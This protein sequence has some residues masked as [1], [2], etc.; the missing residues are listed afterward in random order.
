MRLYAI[1]W[2]PFLARRKKMP[3][4]GDGSGQ[5]A[6]EGQSTTA[7]SVIVAGSY[8]DA[9]KNEKPAGSLKFIKAA[10]D[11]PIVESCG[12]TIP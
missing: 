11:G 2:L 5:L 9:M 3:A 12:R 6:G 4:V 1:W 10:S 8:A 7:G